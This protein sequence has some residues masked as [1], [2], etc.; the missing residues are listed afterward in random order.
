MIK[1][2]GSSTTHPC[3]FS[4]KPK[5]NPCACISQ[6]QKKNVLN[7]LLQMTTTFM[8]NIWECR[9]R[10]GGYTTWWNQNLKLIIFH[11]PS[12]SVTSVVISGLCSHTV[13]LSRFA[14]FYFIPFKFTHAI[15]HTRCLRTHSKLSQSIYS[16]VHVSLYISR[17][18]PFLCV[19]LSELTNQFQ[20]FC[21]AWDPDGCEHIF[22]SHHS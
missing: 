12:G 11:T 20:R 6:L 9:K 22:I 8:D 7:V 14:T 4:S 21:F 1:Y 18:L 13:S 10:R 5:I 15:C 17:P 3:S 16:G 19:P 2:L